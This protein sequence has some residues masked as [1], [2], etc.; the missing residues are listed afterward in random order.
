MK[1]VHDDG[2]DGLNT[3]FIKIFKSSYIEKIHKFVRSV[4]CGNVISFKV[5]H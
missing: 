5:F 1:G 2:Y 3:V 4:F